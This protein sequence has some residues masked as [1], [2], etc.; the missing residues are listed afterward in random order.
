M[1]LAD[2]YHARVDIPAMI[3]ESGADVRQADVLGEDDRLGPRAAPAPRAT[4]G[5]PAATPD[6]GVMVVA[7]G[8][9][10]PQ[11]NARTATVAPTS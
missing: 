4:P 6:V 8:S 2:A 11:A 9:S 3:A 1:L 7:V 5:C 10:R